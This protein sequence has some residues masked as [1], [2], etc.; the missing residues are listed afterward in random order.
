MKD[1][2]D[3]NLGMMDQLKRR[4]E[5]SCF[6]FFT[7]RQSMSSL[8][9]LL[10]F[11]II[12]KY[13]SCLFITVVFDDLKNILFD[14]LWHKWYLFKWKKK[15]SC[16]LRQTSSF[17]CFKWN[18]EISSG[19]EYNTHFFRQIWDRVQGLNH[20]IVTLCFEQQVNHIYLRVQRFKKRPGRWAVWHGLVWVVYWI[21][22]SLCTATLFLRCSEK[23][24]TDSSINYIHNTRVTQTNRA[25]GNLAA[26]RK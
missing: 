5:L 9:S 2:L 13:N 3:F 26:I 7:I 25:I 18:G 8:F 24:T 21:S 6:C 22:M 12:A 16:V 20:K 11:A 14:I 17:Y 4:Q 15:I 23:I 19:N 10:P 1:W